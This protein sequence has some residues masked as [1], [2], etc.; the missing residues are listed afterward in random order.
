MS[1]N[2]LGI[3]EILWDMLPIGP[4][5]GGAPAN[6]AYHARALGASASVITRIGFDD[7]GR[8]IRTRLDSMRLP[9]DLVQVDEV[10][11]TGTVTV[12]LSAAGVPLFT[13]HENVAWDRLIPTEAA[14]E[15]AQRADVICFGTLAQRA[16]PSRSTI[17]RLI[18]QARPDALRIFDI[19]LRQSFYSREV[20]E[21]SLRLANV[22][23]L[24]DS[25][26]PVLASLLELDGAVEKQ[27]VW[28][29][30]HYGLTVV[31]L[32]RGPDGSLLHAHGRWS[33]CGTRPVDVKD[34]VG[35]GDAFTAALAMGLLHKLDLDE[36][37][38]AA[39]EVA[40]HVCSCAGATP[41]LPAALR[42][43]FVRDEP[44]PAEN[45]RAPAPARS[46]AAP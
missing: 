45:E 2:V 41:V 39:N 46:I 12:D 19:N 25:E 28:L 11:P 44:A 5:M 9:L 8:D 20:I 1:L 14:L 18:Q 3:G 42:S 22:L 24:N 17:H 16:E 26:L 35:A 21:K 29:A 23:K 33:D 32:T 10:A 31:A 43:L 37:N 40:R 4:Q 30:E 7:L 27:I 15:A 6:F 34:T 13:I 36:I 38:F